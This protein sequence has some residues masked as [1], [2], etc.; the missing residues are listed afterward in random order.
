MGSW[1]VPH[2]NQVNREAVIPG[3][4]QCSFPSLDNQTEYSNASVV[5]GPRRNKALLD[6]MMIIIRDLHR[7]YFCPRFSEKIHFLSD[8]QAE[9]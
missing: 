2:N 5:P 4:S 8:K 7:K 3:L 1:L 6:K 9:V